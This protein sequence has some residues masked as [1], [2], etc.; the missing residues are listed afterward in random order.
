M[1]IKICKPLACRYEVDTILSGHQHPIHSHHVTQIK[2]IRETGWLREPVHWKWMVWFGWKVQD[3]RFSEWYFWTLKSLK[4][5]MVWVCKQ[6]LTF[7]R[8]VLP[9][10][11][12]SG[13][14]LLTHWHSLTSQKTWV[15][16]SIKFALINQEV[17]VHTCEHMKHT[18]VKC[19]NNKAQTDARQ[20]VVHMWGDNI[21]SVCSGNK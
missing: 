10:S 8:P 11:S 6:L 5:Y 9:S 20:V 14:R 12:G 17:L 15:I 7:Q 19:V 13:S 18:E 2:L 21:C 4:C 1:S 16:T 3:S